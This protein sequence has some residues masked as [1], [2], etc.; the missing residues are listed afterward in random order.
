MKGQGRGAGALTKGCYAARVAAEA[1]D[2][3]LDP[4]EG[5]PL[6]MKGKVAGLLVV[7]GRLV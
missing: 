5:Q 4:T 2:V 3:P 7:L 1:G 6:V